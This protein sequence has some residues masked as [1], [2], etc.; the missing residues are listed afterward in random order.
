MTAPAVIA[1]DLGATSGRVIRATVGPDA[2]D[3]D[4]VARFENRP[5]ALD[6][7]LHWDI[8][9]LWADA[10]D[11]IRA[12]VRDG[13]AASIG[14]DA[15]GVDYGLLLG[16]VLLSNPRHYRDPRGNRGRELVHRSIDPSELYLRNGVQQLP[17]NTIYQLA[18]ENED[19]FLS[20]ADGFL[21]VPDLLGYWLTGVAVAER[22]IASTSGL[23]DSRT[24]EWDARLCHVAGAQSRLLPPLI[25]AGSRIGVSRDTAGEGLGGLEV[26]AVGA[27]D[28]ASAFAATPMDPASSVVISCGTWGLVGVEVATP[29]LDERGL[30]AGFTNELGVDG[31]RLLLRN[32]MGLWLLSECIRWWGRAGESID[33]PD[34]V[35]AAGAMPPSR[36]V[37]DVDAPEFANP[38][39][40]PERIAGWFRARGIPEPAGRP[41]LVRC[42]IDSL[43]QAFADAAEAAAT[44]AGI[45]TTT[46]HV[47]G[48]G[49]LNVVLCQ[50]LAD[51]AGIPV[52]AGPVEATAVGNALLQA[53]TAGLLDGGLDELRAVV[54]RT[55]TG[56]RYLPR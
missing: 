28:T 50:A 17:I 23:L 54:M 1:L 39:D 6:G 36:H 45:G 47:V 31:R 16:G 42:I 32:V 10:T 55:H 38:G 26:V 44:L 15:W 22:T 41:A 7:R 33:L 2:I 4:T 3:L 20:L 13:P 35:S 56:T 48:G 8:L 53:R 43:A 9:R 40:L 11:G 37:F 19:G 30:R 24:G 27:H 21:M 51:R 5:V 14:I 49:A 29:V 46:I 12:V 34:L 18:A 52:V 25:D